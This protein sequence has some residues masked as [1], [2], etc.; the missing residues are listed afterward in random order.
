MPACADRREIEQDENGQAGI[1][2]HP[3]GVFDAR[4]FEARATFLFDAPIFSA[5]IFDEQ[6][7]G[8]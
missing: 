4:A 5:P 6:G 8:G 1:C 3:I 2:P 7:A